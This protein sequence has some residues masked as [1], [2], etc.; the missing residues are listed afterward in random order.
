MRR[1]DLHT[2]Q[3]V[4]ILKPDLDEPQVDQA[5][6]KITLLISKSGGAVVKTEKW[7]KKR[8]AYRVQKN[9]FGI[10]LNIY[11]TCESLK[12]SSL[13]N[14]YKLY[15]QL[16]KHMTVRLNQSELDWAMGKAADEAAKVIKPDDGDDDVIG[17]DV[18]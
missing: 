7:G 15:D 18:L 10:Y 4:I 12:V 6:E 1:I 8:L 11:H 5:I 16:I 17:E 14:E 2:Y 3:S 9:R 13:E